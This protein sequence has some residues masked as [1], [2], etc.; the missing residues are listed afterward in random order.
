MWTLFPDLDEGLYVIK[1][2]NKAVS[3]SGEFNQCQIIG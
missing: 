1:P 2:D 3:S